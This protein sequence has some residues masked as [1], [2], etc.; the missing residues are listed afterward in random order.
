MKKAV[1]DA[2]KEV[3]RA[4]SDA[5]VTVKEDG[6]GGAYLQVEPVDLGGAYTVGTRITWIGFKIAFNYPFADLYP[7]HVRSDLCR[8]DGNALG[9]GMGGS[10]FVPFGIPS[11]QLSR[12]TPEAG[13]IHQTALIKLIKVIDWAIN[14]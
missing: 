13:W 7:H 8:V 1:A 9:E 6:E 12:R 3:E 4:F 5:V 10:Q 2:I 11:I 14:R